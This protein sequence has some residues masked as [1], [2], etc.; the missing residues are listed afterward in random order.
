MV[1]TTSM[2]RSEGRRL[3]PAS[4]MNVA[5]TP[6]N[7]ITDPNVR[8]LAARQEPPQVD[9]TWLVCRPF[10]FHPL[11]TYRDKYSLSRTVLSDCLQDQA[12]VPA[13]VGYEARWGVNYMSVSGLPLN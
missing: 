3:S 1:Y 2:P 7:W 6:S 12:S 13:W 11:L 10:S 4:A 8:V 9:L 5:S